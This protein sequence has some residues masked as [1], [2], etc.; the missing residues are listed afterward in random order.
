MHYEIFL[1]LFLVFAICKQFG[2]ILGI[3]PNSVYESAKSDKFY[4]L[5]LPRIEIPKWLQFNHQ[6]VGNSISL[7]VGRK[8]PKLAVCISFR[9]VEAYIKGYCEVHFSINGYEWRTIGHQTELQMSGYLWLFFVPYWELNKSNPS[10]Q[11]SKQ[12]CVEVICEIM[13]RTKSYPLYKLG[14]HTNFVKWLGANVECI[15][16]PKKYD[17]SY[18]SLPSAC[19]SS[20]VPDDGFSSFEPPPLLPFIP[21]S[22]GLMGFQQLWRIF[23]ASNGNNT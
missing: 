3:L 21:T 7:W 19:G 23:R 9:P 13:E 4:G 22:R 14:N 16:C 17:I 6:R 2:E 1:T 20:S 8:F 5:R 10:E 18:L 15:C 11:Q 12:N